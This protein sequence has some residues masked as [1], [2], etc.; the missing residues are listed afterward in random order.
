MTAPI[1]DNRIEEFLDALGGL[2]AALPELADDPHLLLPEG[3][4]DSR[5][6]ASCDLP[7]PATALDQVIEAARGDDL[8]GFYAAG[9][10]YRAFANSE[11][12]RN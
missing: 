12:Q 3:V 8:V 11:G 1:K 10:V 4:A 2:R 6:V 7:A 5:H 9:P